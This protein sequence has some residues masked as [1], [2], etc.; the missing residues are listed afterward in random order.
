[1]KRI[2]NKDAKQ[3]WLGVPYSEIQVELDWVQAGTYQISIDKSLTSTDWID[4]DINSPILTCPDL[5]F[6]YI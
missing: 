3:A 5:P 2:D 6:R 1:M 4:P